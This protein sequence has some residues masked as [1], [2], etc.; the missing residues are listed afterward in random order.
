MKVVDLWDKIS[1]WVKFSKNF[2][3]KKAILTPWMEEGVQN[4]LTQL[5]SRGILCIPNMTNVLPLS[6]GNN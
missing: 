3:K 2:S 6:S 5:G 4:L 1:W